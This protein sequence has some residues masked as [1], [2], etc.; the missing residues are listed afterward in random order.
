VVAVHVRH[1]DLV[2][3]V[4][5]QSDARQ[6]RG[7]FVVGADAEPRERD[8]AGC[9]GLPRVD[10]DAPAVVRDEPRV[11]RQRIGERARREAAA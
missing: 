9:R 7:Q 2:E 3:V 8:V 11:D 1:D 4:D 10:E 6:R 5:G